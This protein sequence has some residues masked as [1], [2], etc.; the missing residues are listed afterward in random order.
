MVADVYEMKYGPDQQGLFS[1]TSEEPV[2]W[3]VQSTG[4][5]VYRGNAWIDYSEEP[6]NEI[7]RLDRQTV[8]QLYVEKPPDFHEEIWRVVIKYAPELHGFP[9]WEARMQEAWRTRSLTHW[10]E[11]AWGGGRF[12]GNERVITPAYE[13]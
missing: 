11:R 2:A 9:L 8:Q 5:Q 12:G 7:W 4:V 13:P 6:R 3:F 1:I 10:T